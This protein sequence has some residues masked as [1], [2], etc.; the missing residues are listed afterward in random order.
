[1]AHQEHNIA[2]LRRLFDGRH[3]TFVHFNSTKAAYGLG[4]GDQEMGNAHCR[5]TFGPRHDWLG[6]LD[7]D[8]FLHVVADEAPN[9][10]GS[11]HRLLE[12]QPPD[13]SVISFFSVMF[14]ES[15]CAAAPFDRLGQT[16]RWHDYCTGRSHN[17]HWRHKVFFRPSRVLWVGV[18]WVMENDGSLLFGKYLT[19][20]TSV[21]YFKHTG[22]SL[23]GAGSKRGTGVLQACKG[24][25]GWFNGSRSRNGESRKDWYSRLTRTPGIGTVHDS[26]TLWAVPVIQRLL[27]KVHAA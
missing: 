21:A 16:L 4:S 24:R 6:F 9:P 13:V 19:L 11:L 27:A 23:T 18:H 1:M 20:P 7:T 25:D 10:T 22:W 17:T 26:G 12:A 15:G 3:V 5:Y 2:A 14:A 8:E